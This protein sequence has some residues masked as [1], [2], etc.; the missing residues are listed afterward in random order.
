MPAAAKEVLPSKTIL[1]LR[2][3]DLDQA[4]KVRSRNIIS[5]VIVAPS[6]ILSSVLFIEY[7]L[8]ASVFLIPLSLVAFLKLKA[9]SDKTVDHALTQVI[10]SAGTIIAVGDKHQS[11]SNYFISTNDENWKNEVAFI[12]NSC[13]LIIFLPNKTNGALWELEQV[14]SNDKLSKKTIFMMPGERLVRDLFNFSQIWRAVHDFAVER[15]RNFPVYNSTGMAFAV[16][17]S[18]RISVIVNSLNS[19]DDFAQL[20]QRAIHSSL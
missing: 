15:V 11:L 18:G 4:V 3:F 7:K 19:A 8:T 10:K 5:T 1:Y 16:E 2:S 17:Q 12:W 9:S 20:A 6:F 14:L 13:D